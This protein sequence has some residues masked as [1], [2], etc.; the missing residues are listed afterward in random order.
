MAATPPAEQVSRLTTLP[1]LSHDTIFSVLRDRFFSG[2]PYTSLSDTVLVS[3]NPFAASGNRNTDETLREY[4]RH[5]RETN[6]QARGAALPPHIFGLTADAYFHLQRTGQDQV[7]LLTGETSSGKTELRRLAVRSLI[8]LSASAP[9]KKGSKLAYQVPSAEYILECMGNA[10]TLE[11]SNASRFGKYTE[12][13]FSDS[14]RLVGAKTLDYYLERNRLVT[15]GGSE[16]TFHVFYALLAGASQEEKGHLHLNDSTEF[17]YLGGNRHKGA[18]RQDALRFSKLKQAFKNVNLSQR[19]VASICQVLASILHL[20]NLEF[21]QDHH[22]TQDAASVRNHDVLATAAQLL[23]VEAKQLEEALTYK[24]KLIRGEVCTIVLDADGASGN[25]DELAK[26][27]YSLLFAWINEHLNERFC[28]DDFDAFIGILDLPGPQHSNKVNSLD[29]F[30]VNFASERLH[31]WILSSVFEKNRE[32]YA[33]EGI[34]YLSPDVPF[35]DNSECVRLLVNQP[36]GLVHIMD[37]QARRMPKKSDNTMVEAF[38]KRWGNHPNFKVGPADRNGFSSFTVS[39]FHGPVSYSSEGWLDRN[40]EVVSP[41]FVSLL[42]GD[43][44][45]DRRNSDPTTL[46]HNHGSSLPFV[47]NL[48]KSDT[49]KTQSHPKSNETVVAAQQSVK[50]MRAPSTRRPNRAGTIKRAGTTRKG[51]ALAANDDDDSDEE[52]NADESK[53]GGKKA[54]G[55]QGVA[56]EFRGALDTLFETFDD[57]KSWVVVCLR[58]NDNQLPNQF[59][60]RV[61]KQQIKTYCLAEMARKLIHEYSVSMTYDEFCERYADIPSLAAV[62]MQDATSGLA[63]QKFSSAKEVMNWTDAEA[64][65]GRVKAFL[66][67]EAFRELEDEIRAADPDEQRLLSKKAQLDAEAATRGGGNTADGES[68]SP[69][70]GTEPVGLSGVETPDSMDVLRRGDPF[71]EMSSAALPL[72]AGA[73]TPGINDDAKSGVTDW[74][75]P[76]LNNNSSF[77]NDRPA[78]VAGSEAYAPSRN[79]FAGP[80]AAG[81]NEK[82]ATPGAPGFSEPSGEVAE[83]VGETSERRHW[84]RLTWLLT[85]WVPSFIITALGNMRRPDIR[86]AWREKLAINLMIWFVCGCAVF[87]IAVLGNVICPKEHVYS[88]SE[89]QSHKGADDAY[90]AIRG[91]VFDLSNIVTMHKAVV[92][93]VPDERLL[94]YAGE[95]ATSLFPVQVNA[96][97]NGVT[98]SVSPWVQL[99]GGN[100]SDANA[101]YHD[102]RSFH[103]EDARPDW[104]YESMWLMRSNYRKGFRGYTP[105]DI[106]DLLDDGRAVAVYNGGVYDV[107]DYVKQGNRG[108]IT[109]PE[110]TQAPADTDAAFMAP[111]IIQL[112]T[113]NPGSDVTSRLNALPLGDDVLQR[114]KVCLRNLFF[115]GKTDGRNSVRCQFSRYILL[116]LSIVMVAIIGFKF[117]AAL[118]FSR[119]R[120]PEDHDRFVICQVPCYTEGDESMRKTIDSLAALKYDDKRK[121]LFVICDGMIVGSG[122]DRPTPRIVLDILGADP[123]LDPEPL[124][125]LSIGEG[126]RQH[127]MAK[128]YSGL[129]EHS[130]HVVPYVVVVK[131]GKPTERSRPGN[132]GKR[133]SQLILMRFLN[134]VHFGL[135]MNPME[136]EVYH[137]IKNIIGVNPSF[138]EYLLQVDADTTVDA[139]SLSHFVSAFINDKKIIGLCG[140]TSLSNAKKSFITMLQVYEYY[141]SH[142]LAKAF[143]S[144]F[145]SVTCLPGC[146]SMFRLRTPD[147]HRPLFIA[148]RVVEDYAENRVDTLHTKNLLSLGEDRYLTTLVLKHFGNYKTVFTRAGKAQTAAPEDWG[149]L[150]SQRRRW[151]NSTVHNLFELIRTPGLC[152]FCLFSMRFIVFIDLLSTIIA[153]V[154]VA[155]IVYLIVLVSTSDAT[156]PVTSLIML[157]AIYGLQAFIFILNRKFEMIGWM[158]VYIIGIPIWSFFL[159]LYSF[160]HMDDFSWGNTR[161]VTGEQGQKVVVHDEGK[162]DPAEIPLQTWQDYENEL[163]ERN[164]ARSI[165][166]I[167]HA[168]QTKSYNGSQAGSMYEP[169]VYGATPMLPRSGSYAQSIGAG[170]FMGG[171]A[172]GSGFYGGGGGMDPRQSMYSLQQQQPGGYGTPAMSMYGGFPQQPPQSTPSMYGM[173][174]GYMSHPGSVYGMP[175]GGNAGGQRSAAETP[176][177]DMGTPGGGSGAGGLPA[178][179]VIAQDLRQ[180][181]AHADLNTITKKQIRA[182]LSTK[183][184]GADLS[185]KKDFINAT[186]EE[187]LAE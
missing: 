83:E 131:V 99:S 60:A 127:N 82:G 175:L 4:S 67:A 143:E 159:P 32:E 172:A 68:F 2:L 9:G 86:M 147:T 167:L 154:T 77:V 119:T 13:Q 106:E 112:I 139:Y 44:T 6:R 28:R 166:E 1:S 149:V 108:T 153:P 51:G 26:A 132:R 184:G 89:L 129:Y 161:V 120:T 142:Y 55:V 182:S 186:I 88:T 80:G 135:A 174:G 93:V 181:I 11:N 162:F 101:Q 100:T 10:A 50:P 41:D 65:S 20:G 49:L 151:I 113:Q 97:C 35:F 17:R 94:T 34:A 177:I 25:R 111:A 38:G 31:R 45:T 178:D 187:I 179:S 180:L 3:V 173:G 62:S 47:R 114:Q 134:K 165:G 98:G 87:V 104:Y 52:T 160:W 42:K 136:L 156:V 58:P 110:N 72:V 102:F 5:F 43:A 125:F 138:Y 14:G 133:D 109:S 39:H 66:S 85:F 152:G 46:D 183:Y 61:V 74:T 48:F 148:N 63:R 155:Y 24:T 122:N 145:G 95:D 116:A 29:Q 158:V 56:G 57:T 27:M 137:Q 126:T 124:S 81:L 141:I 19:H 105:D 84:V 91:E 30:C 107:T 36:G 123:N 37:D 75:M 121:L 117:L 171:P 23:G 103:L 22:R 150:L 176:L 144:L 168:Q 12:L 64:A 157:A 16:Q 54:S 130:G 140:E 185:G 18:V 59:E 90:T 146:F 76:H 78:S 8:A 115:I 69:F 33:D 70:A 163:W 128:V 53:N 71:K 21:S 40:S 7:V 169:S 118:Q 92:S 164:S 79:M 15:A 96:L 170:S 73:E